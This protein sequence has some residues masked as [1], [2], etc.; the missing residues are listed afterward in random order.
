MGKSIYTYYKDRL[1]E[2]GGS[3]KCLFPWLG[4]RA[5]R[6]LRRF[7]AYNAARFGISDIQSEGCCY[8][9]FK[10]QEKNDKKL[11]REIQLAIDNSEINALDLVGEAEHPSFDKYDPYIPAGLL[12]RAFAADRLSPDEVHKYFGQESKNG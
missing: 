4:T 6:T 8:I 7:L 11:L 5:F 9:T 2:I 12:R 10:S 1:V 3:S